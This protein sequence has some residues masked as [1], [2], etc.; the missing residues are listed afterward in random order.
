MRIAFLIVA[1]AGAVPATRAQEPIV[2]T[3]LLRVRTATSI[4][5]AADGSKAV[6]AVRSISAQPPA[7]GADAAA[8]EAAPVYGYR[9]HLYLLDL[10]DGDAAPR[11]LTFGDRLDRAPRFSPDGRRIAFIRGDDQENGGAQVWVMRA[12]GGEARQ[13]TFLGHGASWGGDGAAPWSPDGRGLIVHSPLAIDEID[14]VPPFPVERPNRAWNDSGAGSTGTPRPDGDR[15]E[16]RAWLAENER[17]QNPVVISRLSFQD[18][19]ELRGPMR[20]GHLFLVDPDD[21]LA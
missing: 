10:L 21:A 17:Q 14:G 1:L 7:D 2:T 16:I 6:F 9:S 20:F 8:A 15:H 13:V 4:D 12:D 18:E 19:E 11:Q 5:V 3:D